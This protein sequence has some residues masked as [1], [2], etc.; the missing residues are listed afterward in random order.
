[1]TMFNWLN[2]LTEGGAALPTRSLRWRLL[3]DP[4]YRMQSLAEVAIAAE[5]GLRLDVNQATVDDWLKLPGLSIRQARLLVELSQSGISFYCIEDLAAA[6]SVPASQLRPLEPVLRF[7][8]YDAEGLDTQPLLNHNYASA[9]QLRRVP[10]IDGFLA[11]T[12]VRQRTARG[13]FRNLADFQQRLDLP[14]PQT[15]QLMHYLC[16]R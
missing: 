14:S 13:P 15:A 1:M 11:D 5:L 4:Y 10:G 8:Y 3:N 9:Q 12:I 2:A 16:F 6:L 7:C